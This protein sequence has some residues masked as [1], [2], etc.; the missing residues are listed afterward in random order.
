MIYLD[1]AATTRVCEDALSAAINAAKAYGNPSSTHFFG[2][3]SARLLADARKTLARLC[4][5]AE[6]E[7]YFTSSGSESN[8]TALLGLADANSRRSRRIISTDG[9]HPSVENT[10]RLLEIRGFEVVRLPSRGGELDYAMLEKL[11]SDGVGVVAVMHVNNETGAVYDIARVR[12]LIDSS[13]CGAR[14]FCDNVQ[15]F[16]KAACVTRFCDAMSASAHKLGG[17]KGSA[18]LYIKKGVRVTP[19]ICGGSQERGFRP[20]T[21]NLPGIC[22]F[23]AAASYAEKLD[24]AHVRG[25]YERLCSKL[26]AVD[27]VKL[28]V[29]AHASEYILSVTIPGPGSEV[30]LNALSAEGICVSAGSACSSRVKS[31]R[32]LEAYGLKGNAL[33][34]TLRVSLSHD[35]TA[36]EID[37]FA[38]A[39]EGVIKKYGVRR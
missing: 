30:A 16:M 23:A 32:V 28:N 14:L 10:L 24:P 34:T 37:D 26:E 20:G 18:L 13:G 17:L 6:D 31:N 29:P 9:E 1:N 15:G 3:E 39:L 25:L 8:T 27:G 19:L 21:E 11:L 36:E 5:C 12:N 22:A 38:A 4:K 2:V 7:L 35:N 33:A